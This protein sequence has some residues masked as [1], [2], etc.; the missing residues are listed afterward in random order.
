MC[1]FLQK[2]KWPNDLMPLTNVYILKHHRSAEHTCSGSW[3]DASNDEQTQRDRG[4]ENVLIISQFISL[5]GTSVH[6][7]ILCLTHVVY[8]VSNRFVVVLIKR[9]PFNDNCR[10]RTVPC[11]L[12]FLQFMNLSQNFLEMAGFKQVDN[13]VNCIILCY[14]VMQNTITYRL[15]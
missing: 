14:L 6:W 5:T 8:Y 10:H 9:K 11:I 4:S 7:P 13:R 2:M 3:Y 15:S 12:S 1:I